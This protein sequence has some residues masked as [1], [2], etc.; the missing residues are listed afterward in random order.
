MYTRFPNCVLT[1]GRLKKRQK[2]IFLTDPNPAVFNGTQKRMA[3]FL[4]AWALAKRMRL[5]KPFELYFLVW[6]QP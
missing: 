4:N 5:E 6:M 2:V 1:N 3:N